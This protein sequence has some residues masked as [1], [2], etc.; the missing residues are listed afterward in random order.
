[1]PT[2]SI[3]LTLLNLRLSLLVLIAVAVTAADRPNILLI[4]SDDLNT[5]LG[6]YGKSFMYTPGIDSLA[7]R[8]VR[9]SHAYCQYPDRKS[10]V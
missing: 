8:G 7:A 9:F 1:M 3:K 2:T 6:C 5:D 10:V 4:V